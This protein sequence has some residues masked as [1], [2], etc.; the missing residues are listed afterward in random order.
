M[1]KEIREA[2][3]ILERVLKPLDACVPQCKL[4]LNP[5][6]IRKAI[7]LLKQQPT[8]GEFTKKVRLSVQSR[9]DIIAKIID[10][11][12]LAV[13]GWIPQ[14]CDRL[15]RAEALNA[16]LLAACEAWMKVES[17]MRDK[18]PC[19]DLALRAHYRKEA[20]KLTEAAIAKVKKEEQRE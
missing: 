13:I 3:T 18:N 11:R 20:V 10:V 7:V 15:D 5:E 2:I 9:K 14:L 1:S 6:K 12:I 17:E 16:D 19:P 8:A 4:N